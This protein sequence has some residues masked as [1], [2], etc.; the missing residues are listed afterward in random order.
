[1]S[2]LIYLLLL[3]HVDDLF[4]RFGLDVSVAIL[5]VDVL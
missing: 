3:G 2:I 1:M 4:G 5:H